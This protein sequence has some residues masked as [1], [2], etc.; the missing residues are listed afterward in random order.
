MKVH[1]QEDGINCM[2][3]DE[4]NHLNFSQPPPRRP[5]AGQRMDVHGNLLPRY[6]LAPDTL[7]EI[8]VVPV[9]DE[10]SQMIQGLVK[11]G[12]AYP[13]PIADEGVCQSFMNSTRLNKVEYAAL[14]ELKDKLVGDGTNLYH[15]IDSEFDSVCPMISWDRPL[16]TY[17]AEADYPENL[18]RH[19]EGDE[20]M[21]PTFLLVWNLV[22]GLPELVRSHFYSPDF[23]TRMVTNN[24]VMAVPEHL[25][26]YLKEVLEMKALGGKK[27]YREACVA[28]TD[29][30][31]NFPEGKFV[32][33][34]HL[35]QLRKVLH[36]G[37]I[38]Y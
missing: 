23:I 29:I 25:T 22:D 5:F 2:I 33:M 21:C 4:N 7:G 11:A 15:R 27:T 24:Q 38:V 37:H 26:V 6:C 18:I 3:A 1:H 12:K 34:H 9:R 10:N 30:K 19:T 32:E 8:A 17:H 16:F 14:Y 13:V 35:C 28:L 36:G 20:K 31:R